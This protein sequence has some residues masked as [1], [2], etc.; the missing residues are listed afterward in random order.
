M[1]EKLRL[2][3]VHSAVKYDRRKDWETR[4]THD[5]VAREILEE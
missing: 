3:I 2:G 1:G 4:D 5:A